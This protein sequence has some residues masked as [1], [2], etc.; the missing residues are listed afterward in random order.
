MNDR[1]YFQNQTP[2]GIALKS[3]NRGAIDYL[4]GIGATEA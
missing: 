1:R 2:L 3:G 4:R